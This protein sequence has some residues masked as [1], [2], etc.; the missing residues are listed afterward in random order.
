M[1]VSGVYRGLEAGFAVAA[2][3]GEGVRRAGSGGGAVVRKRVV[4]IERWV[5]KG[6]SEVE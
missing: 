1:R 4:E 3:F 5:L 2:G 6:E